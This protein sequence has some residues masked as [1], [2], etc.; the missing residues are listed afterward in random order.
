MNDRETSGSDGEDEAHPFR[1]D[2]RKF[3]RLHLGT[4]SPRLRQ[5]A[6]LWATHFGLH[7]VAAYRLSR[8]ARN[9]ASRHPFLRLPLVNLARAVEL[10]MEGLHHVRISA[11]IGPG[12]Y[13]GH[14]GTIFI[15]PTT[16]GRNFSITHGVTVGVGQ[17]EGARGIPEI[18]D[19]VW[20]GT[21][22]VLSG[23]IRI[24]DGVT[25]ANGTMLSRNV[26]PHALVGG[27]PGRVV[28]LHYKNTALMGEPT[29]EHRPRTPSEEMDVTAPAEPVRAAGVLTR[30]DAARSAGG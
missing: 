25:V 20:I 13:I 1:A 17:S 3:Y 29:S 18:G 9:V 28:M 7:C 15:G 27:N 16:I 11:N 21:A 26:P 6:E 23:A 4:T 10:G 24:G 5:R 19:D 8:H 2:L 30:P 22:A 14:A 12:F